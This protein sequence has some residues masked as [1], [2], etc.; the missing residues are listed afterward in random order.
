MLPEHVGIPIGEENGGSK[1]FML[2]I[3]YDNPELKSGIIDD[4]GFRLFL[5]NKLRKYDAGTLLIGHKVEA[6][7]IIPPKTNWKITGHCMPDCTQKVC[8]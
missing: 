1:Y 4:S 2:E 6:T 5:T 7:M 8:L 3:H